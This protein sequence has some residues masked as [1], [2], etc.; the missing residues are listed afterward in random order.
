MKI[1]LTCVLDEEN[2]PPLS[3]VKCRK[4]NNKNGKESVDIGG[5][6]HVVQR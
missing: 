5:G 3:P 4:R 2:W 6:G 1:Q